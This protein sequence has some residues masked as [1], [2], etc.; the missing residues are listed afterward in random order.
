MLGKKFFETFIFDRHKRPVI[1]DEQFHDVKVEL[2]LSLVKRRELGNQPRLKQAF[3][4]FAGRNWRGRIVKLVPSLV[5]S[6]R[7]VDI[8]S[9]DIF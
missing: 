1:P 2:K 5:R 8:R 6:E 9:V 3:I 4:L 7:G